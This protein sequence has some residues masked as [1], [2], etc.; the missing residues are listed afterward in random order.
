MAKQ[1]LLDSLM[2]LSTSCM[3]CGCLLVIVGVVIAVLGG[4]IVAA[5]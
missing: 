4:I 1:G 3:G 5:L 2:A